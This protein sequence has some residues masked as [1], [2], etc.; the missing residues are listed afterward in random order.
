MPGRDLRGLLASVDLE[1]LAD[2]LLGGHRG[3]GR[4]ARWPSPVPNHPQ[5]G[6]S[7]PMSIFTDRT[8]TQRWT[9][10][11]TGRSGTAI[12]LVATVHGLSVGAA[13]DWLADRHRSTPSAVA[14]PRPRPAAPPSVGPSPAL[15]DHVGACQRL[16]WG[17]TGGS[18]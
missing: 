16:L 17:P 18:A 1:V 11:A 6:K 12:D 4:G 13:I 9:C 2:Q 8:G 5:T 3:H 15:L 10:W 7:P 14:P